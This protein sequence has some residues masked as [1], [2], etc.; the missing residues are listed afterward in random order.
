MIEVTWRTWDRLQVDTS[1]IE[2]VEP[3]SATGGSLVFIVGRNGQMPLVV[4]ETPEH[5]EHLILTE[6]EAI[7]DWH[8][9]R[10]ILRGLGFSDGRRHGYR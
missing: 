10:S 4:K 5:V 2:K 7:G 1:H 9:L 6:H 8:P 3:D